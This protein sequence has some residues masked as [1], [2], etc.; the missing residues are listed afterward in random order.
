MNGNLLIVDDE[1]LILEI[2]KFRLKK[3]ADEVFLASNGVEALEQLKLNQVHCVICDINMPKMNGVQ[4]IRNIRAQGNEVP[5]I[6]YTAHGNHEYMLEAAKYGAF[7][8]LSKPELEGIEDVVRH[9][10]HVGISR[11]K[12]HVPETDYIADFMKLLERKDK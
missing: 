9:A 2:L 1:P 11:S 6:F 5:F 3:L 4:V 7:D 8:F 12:G 10:L